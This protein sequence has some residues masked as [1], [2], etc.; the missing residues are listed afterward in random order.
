MVPSQPTTTIPKLRL[1]GPPW[2]N[3][4]QERSK[5]CLGVLVVLGRWVVDPEDDEYQEIAQDQCLALGERKSD[6]LSSTFAATNS[7]MTR[8]LV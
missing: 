5:L 8:L 3:V 1:E 2:S 6:Y 7:P 4:R